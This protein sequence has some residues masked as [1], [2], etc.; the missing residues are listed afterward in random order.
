MKQ[1]SFDLKAQDIAEQLLLNNN[2]SSYENIKYI[3]NKVNNKE[4]KHACKIILWMRYKIDK[5]T[6]EYEIKK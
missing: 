4:I 5:K 1:G 2:I 6:Y 3:Y